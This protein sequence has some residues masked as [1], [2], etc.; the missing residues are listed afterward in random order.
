MVP[1]SK[2]ILVLAVAAA[3]QAGL[4][5]AYEQTWKGDMASAMAVVAEAHR[6]L[7]PQHKTEEGLS[8]AVDIKSS[9]GYPY[10]VNKRWD[11]TAPGLTRATYAQP[12][13]QA[14][15]LKLNPGV[16]AVGGSAGPTNVYGTVSAEMNI[17][18]PSTSAKPSNTPGPTAIPF[19]TGSDRL[20]PDAKAVIKRI[21]KIGVGQPITITIQY[22]K[23][24]SVAQSKRRGMVL[25]EEFKRVGVS[26]IRWLVSGQ[27]G[28]QG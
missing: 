21:A 10:L 8:R 15:P 25:R 27:L 28:L 26:N 5:H 4:A 6:S 11:T 12:V 17:D 3:C 23:G 7:S 22:D 1:M 24:A 18:E 2:K 16:A 19:A 14:Y 20:S 13:S 9:H